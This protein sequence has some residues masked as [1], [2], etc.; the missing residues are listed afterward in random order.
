MKIVLTILFDAEVAG[1]AN[2]VVASLQ[3]HHGCV[4]VTL[5]IAHVG[6]PEFLASP[7]VAAWSLPARVRSHNSLSIV[8]ESYLR[9]SRT[10]SCLALV[11][12]WAISRFRLP[13]PFPIDHAVHIAHIIGSNVA[14]VDLVDSQGPLCVDAVRHRN[15]STAE[16]R[17]T[18]RRFSRPG[19]LPWIGSLRLS[20]LFLFIATLKYT[21]LMMLRSIEE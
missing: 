20:A 18:P 14:R 2:R 4:L 8:N 3:A 19:V 13:V 6:N 5:Y 11:C 16:D 12:I 21:Q 1:I 15:H 10:S 9:S 7:S 17:A